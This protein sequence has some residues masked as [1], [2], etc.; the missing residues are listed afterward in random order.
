M[1]CFEHGLGTVSAQHYVKYLGQRSFYSKAVIR[2]DRRTYP[3]QCIIWTTNVI[4]NNEIWWCR[5][6][7]GWRCGGDHC[8]PKTER[9]DC[10]KC[11][12]GDVTDRDAAWRSMSP[13]DQRVIGCGAGG[14]PH[15]AR[16]RVATQY[17][18]RCAR[19]AMSP[20]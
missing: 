12:Y 5:N 2:T 7:V 6:D 18:G 4:S 13:R 14:R 3:I 20:P 10:W 15:T 17:A 19:G 8:T 1:L 11:V 16:L 9:R